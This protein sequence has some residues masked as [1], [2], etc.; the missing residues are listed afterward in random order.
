[1]YLTNQ[2]NM[3]P[4]QYGDP[5]DGYITAF[6]EAGFD[7]C[8]DGYQLGL[9]PDNI[10][11]WRLILA[12]D[13]FLLRRAQ[14]YYWVGWLEHCLLYSPGMAIELT[15]FVIK[16]IRDVDDP[17]ITFG[18]QHQ[19]FS[20]LAL[21]W[22]RSCLAPPPSDR[23]QDC[24][25]RQETVDINADLLSRAFEALPLLYNYDTLQNYLQSALDGDH[26]ITSMVYVIA[27]YDCGNVPG[28]KDM[29][30]AKWLEFLQNYGIDLKVY[31][32][33][34]QRRIRDYFPS[35]SCCRVITAQ[36]SYN[37]DTGLVI[38]VSNE[39]RPEFSHLD[40]RYLCEPYCPRYKD[41]PAMCLSLVDESLR[42]IKLNSNIPGQWEEPL[43][44]NEELVLQNRGLWGGFEFYNSVDERYPVFEQPPSGLL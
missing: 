4:L 26:W 11:L 16:L 2:R 3:I 40:P 39:L 24:C 31:G 29:L 8:E 23:S 33:F 10:H 43:K 32:M 18:A 35:R 36:V 44:P 19:I 37:D 1:M 42:N 6:S 14:I 38:K 20:I 30:I 22:L 28:L 12:K 27:I 25:T 13:F 5:S 34:E 7:F 15:G 17:N 41:G 9:I 21:N